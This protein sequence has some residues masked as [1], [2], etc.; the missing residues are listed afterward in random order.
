MK[1]KNIIK[2]SD[3]NYNS[4]REKYE[5]LLKEKNELISKNK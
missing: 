5:N 2:K 3:T 4:L 1:N